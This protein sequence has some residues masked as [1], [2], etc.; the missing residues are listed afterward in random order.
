MSLLTVED[1]FSGYGGVDILR[2]VTL[3]V[4]KGE[5]V[6]IIGPNGA[7]KSTLM[8]TVFG[9]L[10]PNRGSITFRGESLV[11]KRPHEIV[12]MGIS[13]VPQSQNVFPSLTV[14]ENLAM[15]AFIR[16]DGVRRRMEEVF[17]LFP[18]VASRP[19]ELVGRL[20]GGQRQMVALARALMLDPSLIL[21][22]EPSAG[23]AP[24]MVLTVF[25]RISDI[26][27][28]GVAVVMVEQNAREALKICHRGYVL[29]MG[30]NR[31]EGAGIELL[32]DE[33]VGKLYL[34]G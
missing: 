32:E 20:S 8:K 29:A 30:E 27:A 12:H 33:Q 15:G 7:G 9:L 5:M 17:G 11:G 2:G 18:D 21:L 23:L 13:Y 16:R 1:V 14:E 3:R 4:E 6:S 22:D 24:G 26:N 31:F 19:K 25:T 10:R 28:S 34:G